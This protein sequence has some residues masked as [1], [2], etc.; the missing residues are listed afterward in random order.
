MQNFTHHNPTQLIFGKKTIPR[1][2]RV[3]RLAGVKKPLLVAGGGAIRENGVHATV[4][5]SLRKNGFSW[6]EYWGTPSNP[7]VGCVR[8]IVKLGREARTDA[9]LAVGGGSVIDAS[10]AAAAGA[11]VDEVW[12][13]VANRKDVLRA[14]PVFVVLTLSGSG[15]ELNDSAILTHK[16]E[17]KKWGLRGPALFPRVAIVDPRA[18]F[19]APWRLTALGAVDALAHVLEHYCSGLSSPTPFSPGL[20]LCETLMRAVVDSAAQLQ[21]NGRDYLARAGLA[22]ASSLGQSGLASAGLGGGDWALH[23]LAH[24]IG[25]A[26]P[27][28]GHAEAVSALFPAW[29]GRIADVRPDIAERFASAT[30][31]DRANGDIREKMT[32]LLGSWSTPTRLEHLGLGAR[33][34]DA[35]AANLAAF[36][37]HH[38][39]PGRILPLDREESL[40]ILHSAA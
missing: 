27:E 20:A 17:R 21:R 16:I 9:L 29:L 24:A 14:L 13:Y 3:L 35:I 22:W 7:T 38:G 30:F 19:S 8:E 18:Q 4:V 15:S 12:S 31:A 36:S 25:G 28:I 23:C 11:F 26:F 39:A 5:E 40:R 1:I 37:E 33:D 2:G 6:S 32:G 34:L 10:K